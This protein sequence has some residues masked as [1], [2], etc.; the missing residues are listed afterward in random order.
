MTNVYSCSEI[1]LGYLIFLIKYFSEQET[2]QILY[3]KM[4][5]KTLIS[6]IN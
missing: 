1:L 6:E 4:Y 5:S 2:G 3:S